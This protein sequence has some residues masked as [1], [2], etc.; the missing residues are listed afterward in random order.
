MIHITLLVIL[1]GF[2]NMTTKFLYLPYY[3]ILLPFIT[4]FLISNETKN[5]IIKDGYQKI[6]D[7]IN[8]DKPL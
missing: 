5:T 6:N 3:F 7:D 8:K 2:I 4:Y 1:L